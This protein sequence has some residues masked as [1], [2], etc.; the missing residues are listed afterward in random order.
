MLNFCTLVRVFPFLVFFFVFFFA[1]NLGLSEAGVLLKLSS[2]LVSDLRG[3]SHCGIFHVHC[4]SDFPVLNM[5][6]FGSS[7]DSHNLL[8]Y[9]AMK[10]VHC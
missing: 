5:R 8:L 3:N 1:L 9:V 6:L 2:F 10:S 4:C 7:I